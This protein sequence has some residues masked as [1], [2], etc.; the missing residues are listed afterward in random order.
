MKAASLFLPPD[1]CKS[2]KPQHGRT[3]SSLALLG[4]GAGGVRAWRR[5]KAAQALAA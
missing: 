5:R 1:V 4:M 3:T 2:L